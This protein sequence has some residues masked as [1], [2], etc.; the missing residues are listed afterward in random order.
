MRP[1]KLLRRLGVVHRAVAE[2]FGVGLDRAERRLQL[3]R[4]VGDEV[5]AERFQPAQLGRVVH[6]QHDARARLAGQ[7]LHVDVD[8]LGAW[9]PDAGCWISFPGAAADRV[10]RP[11]VTAS[12]TAWLRT[13]S[14]SGRPSAA[15]AGNSNSRPAA[16]LASTIR[17]RS[18]TAITP[19]IMPPSTVDCRSRV[20]LS[21][22]VRAVQIL[23]H[24]VERAGQHAQLVAIASVH[25]MLDSRPR[26][27]LRPPRSATSA[28]RR[29]RPSDPIRRRKQAQAHARRRVPTIQRR[30]AAVCA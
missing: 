13:T 19:S 5:A 10:A 15:A 7:R 28:A 8:A 21:C 18:S 16:L 25:A 22:V 17:W 4:H 27:S 30:T 14:S 20:W 23:A 9:R 6:H 2:R 12:C 29:M 3:V 26:R 11:C 1:E 24:A